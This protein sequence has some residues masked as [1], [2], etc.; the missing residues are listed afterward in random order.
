MGGPWEAQV[1]AKIAL[2]QQYLIEIAKY[3]TIALAIITVGVTIVSA[4]AFYRSQQD[5]AKTFSLLVQRAGALQMVTVLSVVVGACFLTV[6]G[7]I[8]PEGIVS[9]LSGIAGYVLGGV[10]KMGL[11]QT[12]P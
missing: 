3:A 10:S 6:I 12:L 1:E 5:S 9:I 4:I 11:S 2:D 8:S 7:K